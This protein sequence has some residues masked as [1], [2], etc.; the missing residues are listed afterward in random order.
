[1]WKI[2]PSIKLLLNSE[3]ASKRCIPVEKQHV[4]NQYRVITPYEV[5]VLF[6][7]QKPNKYFEGYGISS[8]ETQQL[9]NLFKE[10]QMEISGVHTPLG[11]VLNDYKLTY[12]TEQGVMFIHYIPFLTESDE[13]QTLSI[14]NDQLIDKTLVAK[15]TVSQI[16]NAFIV[17]F[18][19]SS[20]L[21]PYIHKSCEYLVFSGLTNNQINKTP[22]II[23]SYFVT[24]INNFLIKKGKEKI[25]FI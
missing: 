10:I 7:L 23:N 25:N 9:K 12:L 3:Y 4:F 16:R 19:I 15:E 18:G 20:S 24:K 5:N 11:E 6:V 8:V 21:I 17:L 22:S 1:M 2:D 13:D 14:I